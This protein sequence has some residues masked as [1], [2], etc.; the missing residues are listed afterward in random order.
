MSGASCPPVTDE[1]D[2]VKSAPV[3]GGPIG[4]VSALVVNEP[5]SSSVFAGSYS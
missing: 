5:E 3:A 2:V 1:I 4:P